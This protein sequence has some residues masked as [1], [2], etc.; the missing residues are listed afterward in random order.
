MVEFLSE[1]YRTNCIDTDAPALAGEVERIVLE[2]SQTVIIHS[3]SISAA[4]P[5]IL[6]IT[7]EL[8]KY[9]DLPA[10]RRR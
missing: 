1:K 6:K 10:S 5:V 8:Q 7:D 3:P 2:V 4:E 9:L